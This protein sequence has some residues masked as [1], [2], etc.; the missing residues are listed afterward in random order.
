MFVA[1]HT[2]SFRRRFERDGQTFFDAVTF[3]ANQSGDLLADLPAARARV[4]QAI[5]SVLGE[6]ARTTGATKIP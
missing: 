1:L 2:Y 5:T 6:R 3:D 4:E